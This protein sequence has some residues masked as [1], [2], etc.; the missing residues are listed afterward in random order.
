M[1]S[2]VVHPSSSASR[3]LSKIRSF[4]RA[5]C[6]GLSLYLLWPSVIKAAGSMPCC[7]AS[8]SHATLL[9]WLPLSSKGRFYGGCA[10]PSVDWWLGAVPPPTKGEFSSCWQEVRNGLRGRTQRKPVF[11][12]PGSRNR[13]EVPR[14][15]SGS[16]ERGFLYKEQKTEALR[17]EP[18]KAWI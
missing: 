14:E 13:E 17:R 9:R 11:R 4:T 12:G 2:S 1:S 16:V 8:Q 18:P 5:A 7:L 3:R 15:A 6:S 10:F